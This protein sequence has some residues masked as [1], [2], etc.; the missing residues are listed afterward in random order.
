M[1]K[2]LYVQ[3]YDINIALLASSQ[4]DHSH[5]LNITHRKMHVTLHKKKSGSGLGTR[6]QFSHLLLDL[7][8]A[9]HHWY[10]GHGVDLTERV[11]ADSIQAMLAGNPS[12]LNNGVG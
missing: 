4:D 8:E 7:M 9:V 12:I 5:F 1:H 10:T 3:L 2:P 6:L 11:E